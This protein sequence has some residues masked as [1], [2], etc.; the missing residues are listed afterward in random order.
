MRDLTAIVILLLIVA[1]LALSAIQAAD[2]EATG[3]QERLDSQLSH[4]QRAAVIARIGVC[5]EK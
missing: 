1:A 3:T 2:I 4:A 5:C